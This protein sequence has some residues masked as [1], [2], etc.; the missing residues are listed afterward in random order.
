MTHYQIY[1]HQSQKYQSQK[2]QNQR[3]TLV[4]TRKETEEMAIRLH[5]T[6]Q[7]EVMTMLIRFF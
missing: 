2:C 3:E 4:E 6:C 7:M 1:H 5:Q